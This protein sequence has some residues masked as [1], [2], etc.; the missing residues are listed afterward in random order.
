MIYYI[1]LLVKLSQI[2]Y[3]FRIQ[4]FHDFF[5]STCLVS[6]FLLF[7][8]SLLTIY[9]SNTITK[10]FITPNLKIY[11]TIYTLHIRV[12]Y[13]IVMICMRAHRLKFSMQL[14]FRYTYSYSYRCNI[15]LIE[16]IQYTQTNKNK[17]NIFKHENV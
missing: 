10:E 4:V 14:T 15:Y 11:E 13:S 12:M 1:K 8:W 6:F 7:Y 3:L 5:P 2:V 16:M 9:G 17:K